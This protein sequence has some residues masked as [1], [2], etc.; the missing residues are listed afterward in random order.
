MD[1]VAKKIDG[2]EIIVRDPKASDLDMIVDYWYNMS[3]VALRRIGVE[4]ARIPGRA[5]RRQAFFDMVGNDLCRDSACLFIIDADGVPVGYYLVNKIEHGDSCQQHIHLCDRGYRHRGLLSHLAFDLM[6]LVFAHGDVQ[7]I[8][9]EPSARNPAPN[10]LLQRC[11]F[12]PRRRYYKAAQGICAAMEV[13]RY[14][15][16]RADICGVRDEGRR[17]AALGYQ[18]GT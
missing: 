4:R 17:V 8:I 13:N 3:D 14:E 9:S 16:T 7:T 6:A 18:S 11:G 5:A 2:V 1:Y 15:V 10:A 12:L